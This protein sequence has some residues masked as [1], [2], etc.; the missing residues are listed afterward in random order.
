M[1]TGNNTSKGSKATLLRLIK[2]M[3]GQYVLI[4]ISILF[5]FFSTILQLLIPVLTGKAIDLTVYGSGAGNVILWSLIKLMILII[6]ASSM[7]TWIMNRINLSITYKLTEKLRN[8][9]FEHIS[10]LPFSSLD[11]KKDGD[12]LQRLTVDI[13][14]LADGMIMSFNQLFAGVISIFVTLYFMF[15]INFITALAVVILTPLSL[16]AASFISKRSF[17]LF[18]RQAMD[19]AKVAA[20]TDELVSELRTVKTFSYEET[21]LKRFEKINAELAGS[22][23]H[24]VFI[25][26]VTNPLT[27]FINA[28]IYAIVAVIGAFMAIGGG[29][30]V[31]G[32][33]SFLSYASQ[34]SKPFNEISGVFTEMQNALASCQRIFEILDEKAETEGKEL[35]DPPLRVKGNIDIKNMSFSYDKSKELIKDLSLSV[36]KGQRVA[37]VGPTGSGKSTLI[38]LLMRFYDPDEG[39]ICLDGIPT[40]NLKRS[41]LREYFAM[42]LQ[43]TWLKKAS[44]RDNIAYGNENASDE[45]IIR[46]AKDAHAHSFIKRLKNGYDEIISNEGNSLSQGEKQL[47]CIARAMLKDAPILLL[48]EATSSIDIRTE[49]KVQ[50]AFLKLMEGK[51]TFVV[52]HRLSTI[53]DS[54]II[55]VMDNGNIVESGTHE[56]LMNKKAYYYNL[57]MSQ[58]DEGKE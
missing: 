25:S 6:A 32:L 21:A 23:K 53:I 28:V 9:L 46:A 2:T 42:V 44:V 22:Y 29:L 34:Y 54:D 35:T 14:Q 49:Q 18:K 26:S 51:T 38:N 57:Y 16:I 31:G 8:C 12:L 37:I 17:K 52:A 7:L 5:A 15:T 30:T 1:T 55:L 48:D 19:K 36:K 13:D 3:K 11:K 56:E 40:E 10:K 4:F 47:I 27:R 43:D 20:L 45:D 41:E 39:K 24:S 33:T 58:F 50:K